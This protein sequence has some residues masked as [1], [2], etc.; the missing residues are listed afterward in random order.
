MFQISACGVGEAPTFNVV[1]SA[2]FAES[3]LSLLLPHAA[4]PTVSK[5]AAANP[6]FSFHILHPLYPIIFVCFLS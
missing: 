4:N 6:K 2:L 1:S 5:S 3:L